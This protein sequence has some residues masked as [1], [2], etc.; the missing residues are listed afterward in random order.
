MPLEPVPRRRYNGLHMS[1]ANP[2]NGIYEITHM[3]QWAQDFVDIEVPGFIRIDPHGQGEFQFGYVHGEMTVMFTERNGKTAAEWT[4]QGN[5]EMD[6]A[7]GRGWS[8]LQ[9]EGRLE[10]EIVFL[11]GDSSGFSAEQKAKSGRKTK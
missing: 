1:Q 6:P 2:I 9:A 8:V 4:W 5:D 11:D 7:S 3:D 10:G